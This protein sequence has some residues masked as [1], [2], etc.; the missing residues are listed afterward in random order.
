[1]AERKNMKLEHKRGKGILSEYL[2]ELTNELDDLAK[3]DNGKEFHLYHYI[4][5]DDYSIK[6]KCLPVRVH[7]GTVGG[8]W[9]DDDNRITKIIIDTKYV[10]KS[11]PDNINESIQKYVGEKIEWQN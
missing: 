10:V 5:L 2:C 4:V 1:M 7:G 9:F 11:Y 8:I 3:L 6:Q